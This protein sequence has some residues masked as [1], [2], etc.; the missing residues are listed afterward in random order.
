M[1]LSW[2]AFLSPGIQ[3]EDIMMAS[4]MIRCKVSC[5]STPVITLFS[6]GLLV[7]REKR[8]CIEARHYVPVWLTVFC[9]ANELLPFFS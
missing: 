9:L 8:V 7:V 4:G 1:F 2:L 3:L 6:V 5:V